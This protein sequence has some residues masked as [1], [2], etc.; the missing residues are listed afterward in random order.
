MRI[1]MSQYPEIILYICTKQIN[2]LRNSS[3]G[4]S[5]P[6]VCPDILSLIRK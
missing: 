6:Q 4:N 2:F 5:G 3:E 1:I